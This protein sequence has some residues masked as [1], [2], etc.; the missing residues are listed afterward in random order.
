MLETAYIALLAAGLVGFVL[1]LVAQWRVA[2]I[3]NRRYPRQWQI[4]SARNDDRPGKLRTYAR[5]QRVLR[6]NIPEL[7]DDHELTSWHHCWRYGPWLAW[8]CWI[9]ALALRLYVAG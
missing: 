8:P 6:S 1:H 7:F 5:L 3:L 4:V 2:R 9:G